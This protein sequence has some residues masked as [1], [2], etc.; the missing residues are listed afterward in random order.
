MKN[1]FFISFLL[2]VTSISAQSKGPQHVIKVN[3]LGFFAGQY[4]M[5]Y[6]HAINDKFSV[7]LSA[8]LITGNGTTS[9]IDPITLETNIITYKRVGYIV[10]PEVRFYPSGDACDGFYIGA[11]GRFR[12]VTQ[13]IDGSD[14]FARTANG[15]A[16]V[17]GFQWYGDGV[18]VDAFV[19][20]QFKNV[21]TNWFDESV[22]EDEPLFGGGNGVRLGVNIGFGW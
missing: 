20:P 7:Q 9:S 17:L 14:W 18:L 4:H 13:S 15:A 22:E 3:P 19:G 1:T 12:S 11:L 6:E 8:G 5:G 2:I 16:A 10:I 21:T